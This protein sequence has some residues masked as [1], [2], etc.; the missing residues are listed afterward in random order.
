MTRTELFTREMVGISGASSSLF[1]HQA[2]LSLLDRDGIVVFLCGD[3]HFDHDLLTRMAR[4]RGLETL[5][6]L[7]RIRIARLFTMHQLATSAERR[8][9]T[10]VLRENVRGIMVSGLVPLFSEKRIPE[11]EVETLLER[12]LGSLR[13]LAHACSMPIL[14]ALP[15]NSDTSGRCQKVRELAETACSRLVHLPEPTKR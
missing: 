7:S 9:E 4:E 1:L 6:V 11:R 2:A 10:L 12:T 14:L 3:N 8:L 5:S 15:G 13:H